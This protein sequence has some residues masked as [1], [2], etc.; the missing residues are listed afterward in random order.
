MEEGGVLGRRLIPVLIAAGILLRLA[1]ILSFPV[2]PLVHNTADTSIYDEGARS[3]ARGE[4]YRWQGK[5]TAFF[6]VGWPLI[7][8]G[9]YRLVGES[10]RSGQIANFLLSLVVILAGWLL[11][12]R[13]FGP[14]AALWTAGLLALAPHQIVYPAFLMSEVAFTALFVSGLWLIS[15]GTRSATS[16]FLAGMAIGSATLVRGIALVY[17]LL[18][19]YLARLRDR[20]SW[21]MVVLATVVM[22]VGLLVTLSPWALRN[23]QVFGRWVIVA[24]DG[25]MNF[26]MGNHHGATGARHE[27]AEGLP[28]T[29]DEV[30]DDREGYRRGLQFIRERPLEFLSLLPRKLFRL[31]VPAPLLTYREE[32]LAKWPKPLAFLL[33]GLDQLLHLALWGLFLVGAIAWWQEPG[34]LRSRAGFL[35]VIAAI[36]LWIAVHLAFLGGARY[37]F[38]MTPLLAAGAA[39]TLTGSTGP[40]S[41]RGSSR[42]SR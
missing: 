34:A 32:L 26:L 13:L 20:R 6:P 28:D 12:R 40:V 33:L 31:V 30:K 41:G 35:F 27:P 36:V 17:P 29:G 23:H 8:A 3:I 11:A 2:Y 10:P 21:I 14:R 5:A 39:A 1:A 19:A 4:G 18:V 16:L 22:C 7:L 38:P 15:R 25:G 9:S 24:N 37:F 42:R